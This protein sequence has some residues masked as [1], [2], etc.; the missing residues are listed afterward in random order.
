[1]DKPVD[2][3]DPNSQ[4]EYFEYIQSISW[5]GRLYKNFYLY[6]RLNKI[7]KG[8]TLDIGCGNGDF[9]KTR[10]GSVG[11]DINPFNTE[12]CNKVGLEAYPYTSYPLKFENESFDSIFL[13]NVLEHIDD[14]SDLLIDAKRLLKKDG[15]FLI[16]VP[17]LYGF[18][19]QSDHKVFYDE[20]KLE[21]TLS[22][23]GFML[24]S[25]KYMPFKSKYLENN[26]N[27]H[28]LYASFV[29]GKD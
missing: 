10:P 2:H 11:C 18:R 24:K 12:F 19:K 1:M 7:L 17:T 9:L 28:C 3:N 14:P 21:K 27:A 29:K 22:D 15:I 20:E 8:K 4:R 25:K 13:D 5:R 16:G 26:L 23:F 6:P